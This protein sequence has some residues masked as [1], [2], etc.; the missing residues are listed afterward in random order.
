[1]HFIPDNYQIRTIAS[2]RL[3]KD[4]AYPTVFNG[5]SKYLQKKKCL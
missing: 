2:V 4:D 1:M 5:F 3:L